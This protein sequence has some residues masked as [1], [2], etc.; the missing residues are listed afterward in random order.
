MDKTEVTN[1][2]YGDFVR[3]TN[4]PPPTHWA[5]SKPSFGT[6]RWP[7]VN[8]SIEDV[9]AFAQW[10]SKRDGVSYRLPTEE[11]WEYSARN[12][13]SDHLYPWG[14]DWKNKLAVLNETTPNDVGSH[15]DG[16]NKWGVQDLIGNVWEWTSSKGSVYPG[17]DTE[18]HPSRQHW[19]AIR[20]GGYVT[21]TD[22][23]DNPVTSCMRS[24]M[25]PVVKSPLLGFRLVR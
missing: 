12:G 16:A 9:N 14:N 7:V 10:R 20:G 11:E 1:A 15:P 22:D 5:G 24:F 13:E 6:E 18:I 25:D 21:K 2:E 19:I 17:N 4:H 23:L 3:E 8:V